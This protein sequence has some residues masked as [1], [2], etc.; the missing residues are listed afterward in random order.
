MKRFF[1]VIRDRTLVHCCVSY[2]ENVSSGAG[3]LSGERA[4]AALGCVFSISMYK[5]LMG[6]LF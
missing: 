3:F 2:W 6:E 5:S 1:T 4:I